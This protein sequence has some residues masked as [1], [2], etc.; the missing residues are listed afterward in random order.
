MYE[1]LISP[2]NVITQGLFIM[3]ASSEFCCALMLFPK[4]LMSVLDISMVNQT[5]E[6]FH[7]GHSD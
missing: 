4:L 5:V 7:L 2:L 6:S 3:L 1:C